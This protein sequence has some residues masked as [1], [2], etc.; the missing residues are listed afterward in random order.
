MKNS[1]TLI[2]LIIAIVL[3]GVIVLGAPAVYNASLGFL[4]SSNRKAQVLNDLTYLLD[5]LDKNVY[6]ATGWIGSPAVSTSGN[7]RIDITQSSGS[8]RYTFN[9]EAHTVTFRDASGSTHILTKRLIQ[10]PTINF[11]PAIGILT[12][13]NIVLRYD[14]DSSA[15]P[16][17]NPSVNITSQKFST[18]MQSL[19]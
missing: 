10:A 5:H 12:V 4:R 3:L 13:D 11:N 2:E 15:D 17:D 8:V 6:L 19:N 16:K 7:S 9:P 18:P 1:L 14:P